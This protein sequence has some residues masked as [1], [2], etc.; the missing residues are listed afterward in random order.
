MKLALPHT[1]KAIGWTVMAALLCL[2]LYSFN[3]P[4]VLTT[5]SSGEDLKA[6]FNRDYQLRPYSSVVKV[7][8]VKVG[9]VTSTSDTSGRRTIVDMKLQ[10]G[11]L[12]KLGTAPR[13]VV[14]PAT[15]LGGKYYVELVRDGADGRPAEGSTIPASRTAVPVELD[16]VLSTITPDASTGIRR[17]LAS[18]DTTLEPRGRRQVQR[19]TAQAPAALRPAATVLRSL[20]GTSPRTDLPNVVKWLR[21]TADGLTRQQDEVGRVI[22]ALD[23]TSLGLADARAPL[24]RTVAD[25]P[26]TLRATRQ[27]LDHLSPTLDRLGTTARSF[28]PSA[29]E[30]GTVLDALGPVVVRARPVLAD[31]RVVARDARPLVGDA[32]PAVRRA[33]GVL[34]DVRGPVLTRADGPIK[35]AILSPWHG[36]GVYHG[37]GNDHRLYEETGYLLANTADVFKYHDHNGAMGRLMAGVGVSSVGGIV[38]MS[39]PEYLADLSSGTPLTGLFPSSSQSATSPSTTSSSGTASTPPSRSPLVGTAAPHGDGLL[40]HLS[41]L[42]TSLGGNR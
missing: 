27:G 2:A 9:T 22:D 12:A 23:R 42:L 28:R 31:A 32:V 40:S 8:G 25:G 14:R 17:T 26:S 11:T 20:E 38:P 24:A 3:Q 18:L 16:K 4:K 10:N 39:L 13:A 7:A 1:P 41:H 33:T 15:L 35:Q 37:G 34:S 30:L 21:S 5:V 6:A 36:T 29:R 19:F